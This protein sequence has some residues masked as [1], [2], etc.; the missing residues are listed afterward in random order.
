LLWLQS[1]FIYRIDVSR[2]KTRQYKLAVTNWY[3]SVRTISV[4]CYKQ[5]QNTT[6]QN[7][8]SKK[9]LLISQL[10]YNNCL[11]SNNHHKISDWSTPSLIATHL[12]QTNIT[13]ASP[14]TSKHYTGYQPKLN[15]HKSPFLAI[16]QGSGIIHH[17]CARSRL[18]LTP[19]SFVIKTFR[20]GLY[21]DHTS[22]HTL[23]KKHQ[24][25]HK[26]VSKQIE[27]GLKIT[28]N[29]S[30]FFFINYIVYRLTQCTEIVRSFQSSSR[31]HILQ[32]YF[33]YKY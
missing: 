18:L 29:K 12:Q 7:T 24:L 3:N 13:Q 2:S 14:L 27:S 31:T 32:Q 33:H 15:N 25:I 10:G 9:N 8:L 28:H 17:F 30:N 21:I 1:L 23:N 19:K 26:F 22:E 5:L 4:Y 11:P 6:S 20:I 16:N